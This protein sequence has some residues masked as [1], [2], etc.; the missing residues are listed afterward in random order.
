[1]EGSAH[2]PLTEQELQD[3]LVQL[4][5]VV[6]QQQ[7]L[8]TQLTQQL[9]MK[10]HQ[11]P[12]PP[13]SPPQ[14][15]RP[16]KISS[17]DTP[18][19]AAVVHHSSLPPFVVKPRDIPELK[20]DDLEGMEAGGKLA[21]FIDRVEQVSPDNEARLQVAKTRLNTQIA[22]LVQNQQNKGWCKTWLEL[23]TFLQNEFTSEMTIDQAW[24]EIESIH[25]EWDTSPHSFSH[26]LRCKFALLETNFP[27]ENFP[28]KDQTIKR[29]IC[30]GLPL[31]ARNKLEAFLEETYPLKKFIERVEYERQ[32]LLEGPP[33]DL[34]HV[35]PK[36]KSA[37]N[38]NNQS[39]IPPQTPQKKQDIQPQPVNPLSWEV[40]ELAKKIEELGRQ[41]ARR[42]WCYHCRRDTH[43][44]QECWSKPQK[45]M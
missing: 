8:I 19:P 27:R 12:V 40:R 43:N 45:Q 13:I 42:R 18:V 39:S 26:Q 34:F 7:G 33:C 11:P 1:M 32:F 24:K 30:Q 6:E 17:P 37:D 23:K 38:N 3:K 21:M 15:S 4:W 29:K 22:L 2:H 41:R 20:L 44:T 28:N 5:G 14:A 9:N 16:P 10:G 25:Y 35:K 31:P 36:L